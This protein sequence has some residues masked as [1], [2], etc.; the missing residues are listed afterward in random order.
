MDEMNNLSDFLEEESLV[1]TL[2]LFDQEEDAIISKCFTLIAEDDEDEEMF[3][4]I[5]SQ[6]QTLVATYTIEFLR[7][8]WDASPAIYFARERR[9]KCDRLDFTEQYWLQ[10]HPSL[11]DPTPENPHPPNS[12][13]DHYR[14]NRRT[15]N[16]VVNH[17]MGSAAYAGSILKDGIPVE[18]QVAVVFWRFANCHFGFR[19]AEMTLGISAGSYHHC[20]KRFLSAMMNLVKDVITWPVNNPTRA[21]NIAEGFATAPNRS[22]RLKDVIGAIDGKNVVIQKPSERGN[23]YV[24]RKGRPS[25]NMMAVC[26]DK[27]RYMYVKLGASGRTHDASQ[28]K[29]S[30]L[31]RMMLSRTNNWFPDNRFI[32]GD[33]AYPLLPNL[34]TPFKAARGS[35]QKKAI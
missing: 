13:R 31:Y 5:C 14:V 4:A 30:S 17:C 11:Q 29:S 8:I 27:G 20:T 7:E 23:E 24:D 15:F 32:I 18:V 25:M 16:R 35:R 1:A 34:M 12:F 10:K 21:A 22:T 26:D 2:Q 28:F 9:K 33:S 6:F 19:I 3:F